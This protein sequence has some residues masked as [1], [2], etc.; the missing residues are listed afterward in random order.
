MA[1]FVRCHPA[2]TDGGSMRFVEID[3]DF[4]KLGF[5]YRFI[6]LSLNYNCEYITNLFP[7]FETNTARSLINYSLIPPLNHTARNHLKQ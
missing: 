5:S 1:L 3:E 6:K 4:T 7:L 2:K